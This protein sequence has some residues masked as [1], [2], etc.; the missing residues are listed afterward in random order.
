MASIKKI[1]AF[2][3]STETLIKIL[4]VF[5]IFVLFRYLEK[6]VRIDHTISTDR[7]GFTIKIEDNK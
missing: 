1:F 5:A 7:Y 3:F 6:G 2:A 4:L